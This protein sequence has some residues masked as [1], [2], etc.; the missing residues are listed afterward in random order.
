MH[1]SSRSY[2]SDCAVTSPSTE[3]KELGNTVL[4]SART[5]GEYQLTEA[6]HELGT[7]EM[8]CLTNCSFLVKVDAFFYTQISI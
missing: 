3:V 6:L 5:L 1:G 7:V 8:F 2:E 4:C